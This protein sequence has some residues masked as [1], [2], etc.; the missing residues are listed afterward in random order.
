MKRYEAAEKH[1]SSTDPVLAGLIDEVGPCRLARSSNHF[2]TL[3]ESIVWQQLSFNAAK[4][5]YGRVLDVVGTK[6]PRPEDFLRVRPAR[7]TGAGLS[8]SKTEFLRDLS[9]F[10]ESGRFSARRLRRLDDAAVVEELTQVK[11]IGPWTAE[12]FLIFGLNRLDVFPV[13]DLGIRKAIGRHYNIRNYDNI[14][15]LERVAESWRPYRTVA[16]WYLWQSGDNT[17][18]APRR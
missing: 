14:A 17:P 5:I 7:L 11:G 2:L 1:L 4:T 16:T 18:L 12:M 13:G 9:R 8:R 3:V 6:R 10:F 15:R